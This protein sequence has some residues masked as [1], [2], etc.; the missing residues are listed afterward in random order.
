[1][2]EHLLRFL[3]GIGN[4]VNENITPQAY[5]AF[6]ID[7]PARRRN[8]ANVYPAQNQLTVWL[9]LDPDVVHEVEGFIVHGQRG[10][11]RVGVILA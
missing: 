10:P 11:M 3:L 8:F 1:M 4:D 2:Y 9:N 5:N 6:W 7:Q